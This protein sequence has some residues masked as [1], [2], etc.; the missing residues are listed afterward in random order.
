MNKV[1][2]FLLCGLL[3]SYAVAF[4]SSPFIDNLVSCKGEDYTQCIDNS[5]SEA[6]VS[7]RKVDL[8]K[9]DVDEI[10]IEIHGSSVEFGMAGGYVQV[11]KRV[12]RYHYRIINSLAAYSCNVLDKKTNGYFDLNFSGPGLNVPYEW[13]WNGATYAAR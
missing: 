13:Y 7:I 10:I 3:P 12:S 8:N 6:E 5:G 9:D 1:F 4:N 2:L 11:L